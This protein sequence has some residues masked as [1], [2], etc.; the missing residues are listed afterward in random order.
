MFTYPHTIENGHGERITFLRRVRTPQGEMLE[1]ENSVT[2]GVGPP[3]HV[4]YQQ[5]E[6]L[7]VVEG[8]MA[9]QRPGEEPRYAGPGETVT[10]AA[11]EAHRFW[12]AGEG[13][14][15]CT[16]YIRPPDSVEYFLGELYASQKRSGGGRPDP[17]EAA[18]LAWRYRDEF[19]MVEIPAFVRRFIF[20][21]QVTLGT[22][23]GKYRKYAGAPPPVRRARG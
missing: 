10:F 18:Y 14:L 19:G 13:D 9:Y 4:H 3:M 11:G 21:V 6:S 7:T 17:F 16:G 23:L 20:P 15:R 12:N 2:A 1:V 22:L 8:K 5:E